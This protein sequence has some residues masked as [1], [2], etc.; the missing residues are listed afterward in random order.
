MGL[1]GRAPDIRS[2]WSLF[3][4]E[5]HFTALAGTGTALRFYRGISMKTFKTATNHTRDLSARGLFRS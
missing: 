5:A 3:P 1:W 4:A 2:N